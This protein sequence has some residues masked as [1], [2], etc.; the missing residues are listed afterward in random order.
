MSCSVPQRSSYFISMRYG[1]YTGTSEHLMPV[2]D[3][4]ATMNDV[5]R[6]CRLF[7]SLSMCVVKYIRHL[8]I[9]EC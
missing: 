1:S 5:I 8:K 9:Y 2:T 4:T 3:F 6:C 7:I